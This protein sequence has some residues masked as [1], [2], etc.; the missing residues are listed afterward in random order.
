MIDKLLLVHPARSVRML[1]ARQILAEFGNASVEEAKNVEEAIALLG[2]KRF[3][4][5]LAAPGPLAQ[6]ALRLHHACAAQAEAPSL[7]VVHTEDEAKGVMPLLLQAS[8]TQ[9]L[10]IPC[11][12]ADLTSAIEQASNPR[13]RR[14]HARLHI[15]GVMAEFLL[16]GEAVNGSVVNLSAGGLLAEVLAPAGEHRH[17]TRLLEGGPVALAVPGHDPLELPAQLLRLQM[18]ASPGG[19]ATLR[20]AFRLNLE[21]SPTR[22][23]FEK[24]LAEEEH[25]ILQAWQ[26][27]PG[28]RAKSDPVVQAPR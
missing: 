19:G 12:N 21:P 8:L 27:T 11:S 22:D 6:D 10:R 4:V 13:K 9:T 2:Q 28:R 5:V 7:L 3:G 20:M 25:K 24:L 16:D 26:Q 15:P 18:A 17:W 23:R 14:M 1:L